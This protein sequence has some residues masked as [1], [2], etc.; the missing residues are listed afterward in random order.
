MA[1]QSKTWLG[2]AA[3]LLAVTAALVHGGEVR[4]DCV[5]PDFELLWTYPTDGDLE[6]PMIDCD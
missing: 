4:A 2:R 1:H 3:V 5:L 6:V